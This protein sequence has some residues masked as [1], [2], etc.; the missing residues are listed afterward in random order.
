MEEFERLEVRIS[1]PNS[2]GDVELW[3]RMKLLL[4]TAFD[5]MKPDIKKF[6]LSSQLSIIQ[7]IDEWAEKREDY[8]IALS[9][10]RSFLNTKT[11]LQLK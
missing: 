2:E 11:K 5:L 9:D 10:L 3:K 8:H 4:P 6:L 7:A 1:S